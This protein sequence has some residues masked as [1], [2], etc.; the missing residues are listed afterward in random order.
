[1]GTAGSFD[2]PLSALAKLSWRSGSMAAFFFF[3]DT[4]LRLRTLPGLDVGKTLRKLT[5]VPEDEAAKNRHVKFSLHFP[6]N[7]GSC[8]VWGKK[9]ISPR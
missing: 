2:F 3:L 8:F 5:Q 4:F 6:L 1:M 7:N 9:K